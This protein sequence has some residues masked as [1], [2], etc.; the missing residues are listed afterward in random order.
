M[1]GDKI[2]DARNKNS[3]SLYTENEIF[4]SGKWE[5]ESKDLSDVLG[6]GIYQD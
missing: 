4:T 6:S 3:T 2:L 5:D 1:E